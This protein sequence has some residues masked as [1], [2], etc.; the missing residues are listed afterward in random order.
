MGKNIG[1]FH[2][3]M[4]A[5]LQSFES[6]PF[7]KGCY[8]GNYNKGYKDHLHE[9]YFGEKFRTLISGEPTLFMDI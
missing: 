7:Y 1:E 3:A 9:K 2:R 6:A 5:K 4:I 8:Y